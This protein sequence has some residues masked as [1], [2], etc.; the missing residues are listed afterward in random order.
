M[1]GRSTGVIWYI[2]LEASL[3]AFAARA[4][5]RRPPL[6]GGTTFVLLACDTYGCVL[7]D[8]MYT[9]SL[10]LLEF[11]VRVYTA[12]FT[13]DCCTSRLSLIISFTDDRWEYAGVSGRFWYILGVT[14]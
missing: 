3:A 1:N 4:C 7:Q 9:F 12:L 2:R 13:N 8:F 14:S 5:H 6:S 11:V 10:N